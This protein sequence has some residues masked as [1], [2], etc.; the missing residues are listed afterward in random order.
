MLDTVNFKTNILRHILVLWEKLSDVAG[1]SQTN[2][3]AFEA[4]SIQ[5]AHREL[6]KVCI[7]TAVDPASNEGR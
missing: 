4:D 5:S 2:I 1:P 7:A 6:R 3:S